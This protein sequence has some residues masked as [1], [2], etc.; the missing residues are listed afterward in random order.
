MFAESIHSIADTIN[1]VILA[2]G[3]YKS[4][5]V[6]DLRFVIIVFVVAVIFMVVI[7]ANHRQFERARNSYLSI[8]F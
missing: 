8:V 3:I 6:S 4:V 5:K 1:Q 2:F 7:S